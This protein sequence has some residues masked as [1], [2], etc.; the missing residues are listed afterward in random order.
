MITINTSA[1]TISTIIIFPFEGPCWVFRSLHLSH[2]IRGSDVVSKHVIFL[3]VT[4]LPVNYRCSK[5]GKEFV[6]YVFVSKDACSVGAEPTGKFIMFYFSTV[7]VYCHTCLSLFCLCQK[8]KDI[9]WCQ[10]GWGKRWYSSTIHDK[11]WT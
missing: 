1:I 11:F 6:K 8:G 9:Q 3:A 4:S 5:H 2:R 7:F 10:G